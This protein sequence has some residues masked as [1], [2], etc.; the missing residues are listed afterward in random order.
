M[1]KLKISRKALGIADFIGYFEALWLGL[2]SLFVPRATIMYPETYQEYCCNYRGMLKW[3]DDRCINCA[4][5]ARICPSGAIKMYKGDV[6]KYPGINYQRC[7][8]CGFC[9]DI[10]PV[11]ALEFRPIH[12]KAYYTLDE[13]LQK[14]EEFKKEPV[15]D[16]PKKTKV[17]F[18]GR[19]GL[20]YDST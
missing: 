12:D 5:C 15:D 10:C 16:A 20:I 11:N 14:P 6:K 4:L 18:D 3:Y 7:I 19:R 1:V 8:F 2:K 17:S 9:R 13:Q